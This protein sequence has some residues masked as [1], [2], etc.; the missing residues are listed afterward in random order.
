MTSR[1]RE[2]APVVV[3]GIAA[4]TPFVVATVR[5]IR[6]GWYPIGDN[7]FFALRARDVLTE[8]HPLLGTWTSASLSVGRNLNNPGPLL[9]DLLAVPAKADPAAGLAIGVAAV[10]VAAIAVIGWLA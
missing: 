3:A 5:A 2:L 8:H 7:A 4:V 10:N 9:F 6:D 1:R